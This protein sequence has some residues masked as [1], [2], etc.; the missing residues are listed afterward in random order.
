MQIV[1]DILTIL[2]GHNIS[3]LLSNCLTEM[4]IISIEP[5]SALFDSIKRYLNDDKN[6]KNKALQ[7]VSPHFKYD[8]LTEYGMNVNYENYKKTKRE[9]YNKNDQEIIFIKEETR[10]RPSKFYDPLIN[11]SVYDHAMKNS[12]FRHEQTMERASKTF[13]YNI[14]ARRLLVTRN[15]LW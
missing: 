7:L 2:S 9:Y 11:K 12:T 6:T 3:G 15:I 8:T 10:G 1:R 4:E 5:I 13:G 14:N